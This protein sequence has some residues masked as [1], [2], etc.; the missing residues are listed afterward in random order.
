MQTNTHT[1][2]CKTRG[3]VSH[4]FLSKSVQTASHFFDS[5][6][7]S[8]IDNLERG[9]KWIVLRSQLLTFLSVSI[10]LSGDLQV[11]ECGL[12][13]LVFPAESLGGRGEGG[14]WCPLK[15]TAVNFIVLLL[16]L[17]VPGN[18]FDVRYFMSSLQFQ[19]H[20]SSCPP[21]SLLQV[22]L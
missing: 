16:L 15:M 5:L 6:F 21:V 2:W 18:V 4:S 9:R 17:T 1:N 11:T 14:V 10:C 19:C 12:V 8:V 13:E 7:T 20:P 22:Y 3:V